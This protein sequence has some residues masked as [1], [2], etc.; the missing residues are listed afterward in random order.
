[1]DEDMSTVEI[2]DGSE[3]TPKK[4]EKKPVAPE[5]DNS[6]FDNEVANSLGL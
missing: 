5:P 6:A 2:D 3:D 1:M 4:Q